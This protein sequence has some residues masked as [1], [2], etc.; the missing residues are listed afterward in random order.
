MKCC[1]DVVD[2]VQAPLKAPFKGF[3][4]CFLLFLDRHLLMADMALMLTKTPLMLTEL[5]LIGSEWIV[6]CILAIHCIW[7]G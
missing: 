6:R 1:L 4:E 5:M 2:A 7:M 3:F